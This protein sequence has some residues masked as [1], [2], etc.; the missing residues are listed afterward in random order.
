MTSSTRT[1]TQTRTRTHRCVA[2]AALTTLLA[3]TPTLSYA[4]SRG[5]TAHA[6]SA[7]VA[8]ATAGVGK[9]A[10]GPRIVAPGERVVGAPGFELWLTAEGKHWIDPSLPG[11]E[12]FRSVVDGNVD[13]SQ[14]GVTLQAGGDEGVYYLS[15]L[16]YGGRGT[17]SRV[18]VD[19]AEGPVRGKLIELAGRPGWGVWYAVAPLPDGETGD[20]FLHKVTVHDTRGRVYAELPLT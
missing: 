7:A 17:A 1:R 2:V 10:P 12:Q 11:E 4:V 16:Y 15:G 14:P 18:V 20:D 5:E 9:K 6:T 8:E 13:L 3:G 19:T